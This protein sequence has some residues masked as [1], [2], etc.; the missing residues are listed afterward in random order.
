MV[1]THDNSKKFHC[2]KCKYSTSR[3]SQYDRH[4]QTDKHK[5]IQN[6]TLKSSE[7]KWS[8]LC[9]KNYKHSSTLYAHRKNCVIGNTP[10]LN[11]VSEQTQIFNQQIIESLLKF[12]QNKT[13]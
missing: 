10:K 3:Q 9:G 12:V 2:E 1:P 7:P 4:L 11:N 8:C 13:I 5:T 6:P